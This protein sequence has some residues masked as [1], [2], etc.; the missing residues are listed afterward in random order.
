[1]LKNSQSYRKLHGSTSLTMKNRLNTSP[2]AKS[3]G[4]FYEFFS[5]LL[6]KVYAVGDLLATYKAEKN[7]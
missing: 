3:R 5:I 4:A 1:M 6:D 7:R 2:R